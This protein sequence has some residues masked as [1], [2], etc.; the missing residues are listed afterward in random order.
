MGTVTDVFD[1]TGEY[2]VIEIA[3]AEP[4]AEALELRRV[5]AVREARRRKQ[6]R[7]GRPP[8]AVT[9]RRWAHQ[10]RML[11]KRLGPANGPMR[12][13]V[14]FANDYVTDVDLGG[15]EMTVV[16]TPLALSTA[17]RDGPKTA[18]RREKRDRKR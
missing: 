2:D 4:V 9:R 3:L 8:S 5:E 10:D 12:L 6:I 14:P 7:A 11:K 1:G 16:V 17:E 18:A 13:L 15:K